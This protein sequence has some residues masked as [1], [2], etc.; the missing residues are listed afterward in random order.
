MDTDQVRFNGLLYHV[1][2]IIAGARY[3]ESKAQMKIL[4]QAD[5]FLTELRDARKRHDLAEPVVC[6]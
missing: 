6:T 2:A 1:R 5:K 3:F 4:K